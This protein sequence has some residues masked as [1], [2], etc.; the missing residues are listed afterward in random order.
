[1]SVINPLGRIT[2]K[3]PDANGSAEH[4]P[5]NLVRHKDSYPEMVIAVHRPRRVHGNRLLVP[6][7][8]IRMHLLPYK[9]LAPHQA[10]NIGLG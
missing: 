7:A 9:H 8:M 4:T 5:L 1:M 10:S 6:N 3:L 2:H